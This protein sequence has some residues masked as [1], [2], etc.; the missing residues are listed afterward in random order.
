MS[1][2]MIFGHLLEDLTDGVTVF[3]EGVGKPMPLTSTDIEI[4]ITSG[5]AA[6]VT[7]RKFSNT[8]NVP[9]EA[10][11]T[12]PVGFNAV[13]TGL[14]ASINGRKLRAVAKP[15]DAARDSYEAAIDDGKMAVLHEEALRGIHVLSVGH[16]APG[17]EVEVELRM[18]MPLS[19]SEAGPFLRLPM[20]AGQLYGSTPLQPADDL[21]TDAQVRQVATL[22]VRAD[23]GFPKLVGLGSVEPRSSHSVTLDRA[24]EIVVEGGR[25]G[26]LLGAS[27]D[28]HQVRVDLRPQKVGE[29]HLKIAVL[30]DRS[31]STSSTLADSA[32]TVLSAM[33]Q[34]LIAALSDANEGDHIAIW[35]FSDECQRLGTGRG[36]EILQILKKLNEPG[37][38]TR[39]GA[40][41]KKVAA[42]G[43]QDILV[44]TDGQTWEALPPLASELSIRVSAVLVGKASLDANIGHLCAMTGGDLFYAPDADVGSCV[45]LALNN[46]RSSTVQREIELAKGRPLRVRRGM[47]GVEITANWIEAK[48]IGKGSDIGRFAAALCLGQMDEEAATVLATAEGLCSQATSLIL[49]DEAGDVSQGL[50]ETRKVPLMTE[51]ASIMPMARMSRD[52]E[53]RALLMRETGT[54]QALRASAARPRSV[55]EVQAIVRLQMAVRARPK[56]QAPRTLRSFLDIDANDTECSPQRNDFDLEGLAMLAQGIDWDIQSNRFLSCDFNGLLVEEDAVLDVLVENPA[57]LNVVAKAPLNPKLVLLAW[58]ARR[59]VTHSRAAQ[60]FANKVLGQITGWDISSEIEIQINALNRKGN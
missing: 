52:N 46:K 59:F 15:K 13:V 21:I 17:I 60:R 20:T 49:V 25:F 37:G 47:G 55:A 45:R 22:S 58:L 6:V 35:Q 8:E 9:I 31:G 57:L 19:I 33:R 30:V 10:I 14:S 16:L 29:A 24:I 51:R 11:L 28:G 1:H 23:A 38:G 48:E 44:L 39:L 26:T 41:I 40:A 43:I 53:P 3:R 56:S 32:D 4:D 42:S 7:T 36:T 18:V 2:Q 34:G 27:A 12:M 50:S 54:S 5:L